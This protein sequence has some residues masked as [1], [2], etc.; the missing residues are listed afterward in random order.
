M[1]GSWPHSLD[2]S[3]PRNTDRVIQP[4]APVKPLPFGPRRSRRY[5]SLGYRAKRVLL[6]RPLKTTQLVHERISR[7]VA[8]AVFFSDPTS[9]IATPPRSSC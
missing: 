2:Q 5:Q 8:S 7:R 1:P 9:S 3:S 6:G 4:R